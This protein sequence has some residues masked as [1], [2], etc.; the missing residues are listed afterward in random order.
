MP[1][2]QRRQRQQRELPRGQ[3]WRRQAPPQAPATIT[4]EQYG[5]VGVTLDSSKALGL[6]GVTVLMGL[7]CGDGQTQDEVGEECDDGNAVD[8]DGCSAQC[9]VEMNWHCFHCQVPAAP[10]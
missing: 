3:A 10:N 6:D 7:I 4:L 2:Q 1:E 8:G 9:V 5:F